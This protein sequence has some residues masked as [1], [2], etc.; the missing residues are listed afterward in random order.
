MG[1]VARV[2]S[3]LVWIG[4]G[5]L[6]VGLGSAA[7]IWHEQDLIDRQQDAAQAAGGASP[8]A[9]EDSRRH[10]RDVEIYYGK[11]GLLMEQAEGLFHGKPLAKTI[12]VISVVAAAGLFLVSARLRTEANAA[13]D[14]SGGP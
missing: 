14:S 4:A 5:I 1:S 12:G 13:G 7:W 2:R 3:L 8:L 11:L 9:P 10:V 6:L